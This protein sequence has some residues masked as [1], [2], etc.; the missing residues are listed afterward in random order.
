MCTVFI[1]F[2]C[3]VSHDAAFNPMN[4]VTIYIYMVTLNFLSSRRPYIY[5][6]DK[7]VCFPCEAKKLNEF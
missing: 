5:A 2:I 6:L 3:L 7:S 4:A 1:S